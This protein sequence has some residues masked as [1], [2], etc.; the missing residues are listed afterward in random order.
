MDAL[1]ET[2]RA[3]RTT[4]TSAVASKTCL[5]PQDS[6]GYRGR[7]FSPT[8]LPVQTARCEA[9]LSA[10]LLAKNDEEVGSS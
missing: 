4:R 1:A 6:A 3:P 7:D 10:V 5:D 9:S 8:S 2:A